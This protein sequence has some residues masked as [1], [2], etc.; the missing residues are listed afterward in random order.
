M[1]RIREHTATVEVFNILVDAHGTN[2]KTL[3][4]IGERGDRLLLVVEDDVG[5]NETN[6]DIGEGKLLESGQFHNAVNKCVNHLII[7]NNATEAAAQEAT[8]SRFR[9]L[10]RNDDTDADDGDYKL[11]D[12]QHDK[13]DDEGVESVHRFRIALSTHLAMIDKRE[14]HYMACH[15]ANDIG[16]KEG[17]E[18]DV[19]EENGISSLL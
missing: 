19:K 12:V 17:D 16:D 2:A 8:H 9:S 11:D 13:R 18:V 14:H 5:H 4:G 15:E 1:L 6:D 10:W 7:M 3:I